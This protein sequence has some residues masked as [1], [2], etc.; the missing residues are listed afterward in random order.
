MK[1]LDDKQ[2]LD[3]ILNKVKALYKIREEVENPET[4]KLIERYVLMRSFDKNWQDHLTEMEDLR[5]S[6]GLRSYG[7]KD[8]LN[9]YKRAAYKSFERLLLKI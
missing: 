8:P 7:Q 6:V 1:G 5:K 2:M 9:E 3:A 4:L